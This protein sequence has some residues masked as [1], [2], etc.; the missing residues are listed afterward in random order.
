MVDLP[1]D[2]KLTE[3]LQDFGGSRMRFWDEEVPWTLR[4]PTRNELLVKLQQSQRQVTGIE[5]AVLPE[6]I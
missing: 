1:C 3:L 2:L 5:E 6:L 4:L